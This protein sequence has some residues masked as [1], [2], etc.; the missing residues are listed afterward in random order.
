MGYLASGLGGNTPSAVSEVTPAPVR[1]SDFLDLISLDFAAG[2]TGDSWS[3]KFPDILGEFLTGD[4]VGSVLVSFI[5][6]SG[7]WFLGWCHRCF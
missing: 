1:G 2:F 3:E 6:Q 7:W 5:A 4:G